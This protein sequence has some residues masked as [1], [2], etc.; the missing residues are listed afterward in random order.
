MVKKYILTS[1]RS[2][3]GTL[4]KLNSKDIKDGVNV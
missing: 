3:K 1:S 4:D 2:Y